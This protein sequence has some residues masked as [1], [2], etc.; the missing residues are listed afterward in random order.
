[1]S[2]AITLR[3]DQWLQ[4]RNLLLLFLFCRKSAFQRMDAKLLQQFIFVCI[5]KKYLVLF[6]LRLIVIEIIYI[7]FDTF[8]NWV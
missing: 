6:R 8:L 5:Q 2:F 1:M 7:D 4:R 3:H